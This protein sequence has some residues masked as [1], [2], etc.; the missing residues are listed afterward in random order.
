ME[1]MLSFAA[2]LVKREDLT[3]AQLQDDY[4][5]QVY[6]FFSQNEV[7]PLENDEDDD[8]QDGTITQITKVFGCL[9]QLLALKSQKKFPGTSKERDVKLL[10]DIVTA[11]ASGVKEVAQQYGTLSRAIHGSK[12]LTLEA[13]LWQEHGDRIW[14][15]FL[16]QESS[17]GKLEQMNE[18]EAN[19]SIN[20]TLMG[21]VRDTL[22]VIQTEC[23][24]SFFDDFVSATSAAAQRVLKHALD[25]HKELCSCSDLEEKEADNLARIETHANEMVELL[26]TGIP[27]DEPLWEALRDG[28]GASKAH[29]TAGAAV[30]EFDARLQGFLALPQGSGVEA[31][32]V[33]SIE[34]LN[35]AIQTLKIKASGEVL[36]TLEEKADAVLGK[37]LEA[38]RTAQEASAWSSILD[39][40]KGVLDPNGQRHADKN[41]AIGDLETATRVVQHMQMWTDL[42]DTPEKR[43]IAVDAVDVA[44]AWVAQHHILEQLK[45]ARGEAMHVVGKDSAKA[46]EEQLKDV[47]DEMLQPRSARCSEIQQRLAQ[48]ASDIGWEVLRE[49][50]DDFDEWRPRVKKNLMTYNLSDSMQAES[51]QFSEQYSDLTKMHQVFGRDMDSTA[52]GGY[53]NVA[54][55]MQCITKMVKVMKKLDEKDMKDVKLQ[56]YQ[57]KLAMEIKMSDVLK[58]GMPKS[59]MKWVGA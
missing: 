18:I 34:S 10:N 19:G 6:D 24:E 45:T 32:D 53:D 55:T 31:F 28:F 26:L 14:A 42:G 59:L 30:K 56:R 35:A 8:S 49:S 21:V 58:K 33:A 25:T 41:K 44:K 50:V 17:Q 12:L 51:E 40:L 37:L 47:A 7:P 52:R 9:E 27:E 5:D 2:H 39:A 29:A 54:R 4:I 20:E 15:V 13:G 23:P 11:H 1:K 22:P 3:A 57:K 48:H 46:S 38:I 16:V 36:K 43:S